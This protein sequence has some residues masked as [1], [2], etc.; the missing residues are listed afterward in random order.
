[1]LQIYEGNRRCV[2]ISDFIITTSH[3]PPCSTHKHH[4]YRVRILF[5]IAQNDRLESKLCQISSKYASKRNRP[6]QT[7][8]PIVPHEIFYFGENMNLFQQCLIISLYVTLFSMGYC[9][10]KSM[11]VNLT[12]SPHH[13]KISLV[14]NSVVDDIFYIC[15]K[16]SN[17][18]A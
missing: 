11:G 13:I 17:V 14:K 2:H 15:F 10:R 9:H 5:Y 12:I 16:C 6:T 8:C 3:M 18:T 4:Y 1:M 7:L